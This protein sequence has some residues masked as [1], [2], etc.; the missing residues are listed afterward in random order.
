M[1]KKILFVL[2][3]VIFIAFIGCDIQ[4]S[5]APDGD[6]N[7]FPYA[8]LS[9]IVTI[10]PSGTVT[11][12][13]L[14]AVSYS[15]TEDIIFDWH[16]DGYSFGLTDTTFT[17]GNPGIYTVVVSAPGF[18]SIISNSVEVILNPES[19]EREPLSNDV[20]FYEAAVEVAK[21][22]YYDPEIWYH[23]VEIEML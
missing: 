23:I 3:V 2:L 10:S 4:I 5:Y 21:M 19:S 1:M 20:W 18:N 15:G 8:N 12:G 7:Y 6:N 22:F 11:T 17:P 16:I 14:L 13:T 9:G